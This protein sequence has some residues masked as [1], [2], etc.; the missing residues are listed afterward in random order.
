[1]YTSKYYKNTGLQLIGL[2]L[3]KFSHRRSKIQTYNTVVSTDSLPPG[4]KH[5]QV[6]L[7]IAT[8]SET[9]GLKLEL[10]GLSQKESKDSGFSNC[11]TFSNAEGRSDNSP[12]TDS[13]PEISRLA[14][15]GVD[16]KNW[17]LMGGFCQ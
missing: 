11:R 2:Q 7:N 5:L 1:M 13:L 10:H 4:P 3:L 14:K 12:A 17:V 6:N 15:S 8:E 9:T 16:A